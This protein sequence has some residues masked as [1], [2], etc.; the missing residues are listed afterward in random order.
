MKGSDN[1]TTLLMYIIDQ[2]EKE[3]KRPFFKANDEEDIQEMDII[4]KIPIG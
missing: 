3:L 1:K 4:M 2:V